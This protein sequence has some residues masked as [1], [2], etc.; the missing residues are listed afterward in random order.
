MNKIDAGFISVYTR[1]MVE[2]AATSE[3][4][5]IA[6]LCFYVGYDG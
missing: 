5:G 3:I 4:R 2:L 1:Q 6:F